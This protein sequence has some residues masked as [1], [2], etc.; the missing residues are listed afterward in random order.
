M[1]EGRHTPLTLKPLRFL[2]WTKKKARS[3]KL[4]HH[5]Y[6]DQQPKTHT[7]HKSDTSLHTGNLKNLAYPQDIH[8][9]MNIPLPSGNQDC[10]TKIIK[11]NT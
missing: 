1:I 2:V 7:H 5:S 4:L 10:L 9:K 11:T 8:Y 6:G 3:S